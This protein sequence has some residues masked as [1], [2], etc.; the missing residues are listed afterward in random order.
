MDFS[1][2]DFTYD[3]YVDLHV[4][5]YG[6]LSGMF[7]TSNANLAFLAELFKESH[8]WKPAFERDGKQY[9]M[10]FVDAG[11]LRFKQFMDN[12]ALLEKQQA[13][14]FYQKNGFHE[15]TH[16]FVEIWD[17]NDI[18]DV[19]ISFPVSIMHKI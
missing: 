15:Q 18:S 7:Y 13:E 3:C 8:E 4:D 11:D 9:V 1:N 14:D 10:G 5:G 12:E 2:I 6:S 17:D 16:D 19:Q